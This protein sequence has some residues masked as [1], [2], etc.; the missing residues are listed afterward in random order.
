M[1]CRGEWNRNGEINRDRKHL[2]RFE[3][4]RLFCTQ[5]VREY[6]RNLFIFL[7]TW[8]IFK[9]FSLPAKIEQ[10]GQSERSEKREEENRKQETSRALAFMCQYSV[11]KCTVAAQMKIDFYLLWIYCIDRVRQRQ[12]RMDWVLSAAWIQSAIIDE[13][14]CA[15]ISQMRIASGRKHKLG[16]KMRWWWWFM[17]GE[18]DA[19]NKILINDD[20]D[21]DGNGTTRRKCIDFGQYR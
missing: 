11:L 18:I 9:P 13:N 17:L 21:N 3:N 19:L 10:Y 14:D 15:H 5:S 6:N 8:S 7:I 4:P 16:H 12:M 2:F 1:K 20:Y